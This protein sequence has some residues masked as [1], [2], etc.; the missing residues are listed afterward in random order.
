[1]SLNRLQRRYRAMA[2]AYD[3]G[4]AKPPTRKQARAWLAPIRNAFREIRTGEVDTVRGYA[5]TTITW[6]RDDTPARVDHCINGFA[7][8]L[9]R[10]APEFD[11]G[12]MRKVSKKLENGILLTVEDVDAC[13][14]LL[15]ACED[16]LLTFS[17]QQLKGAALT[18]QINIEME[19]LGLK[20]AA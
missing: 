19:M 16:L 5:V 14:A 12:P 9:E 7:A 2:D 6:D 13:F 18:E 8:M 3:A 17:R 4:L 1:M 15:N 10:L 11:I 20:D